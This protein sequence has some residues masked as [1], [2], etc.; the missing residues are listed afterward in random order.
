MYPSFQV[1]FT[2]VGPSIRVAGR[3]NSYV[4]FESPLRSVSIWALTAVAIRINRTLIVKASMKK[5]VYVIVSQRNPNVKV[6]YLGLILSPLGSLYETPEDAVVQNP[7]VEP[8]QAP[9]VKCG[10]EY[11]LCL[12]LIFLN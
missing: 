7:A 6:F 12:R 4:I 11:T 10:C 2:C 5:T 1:V 3:F 9:E 8:L